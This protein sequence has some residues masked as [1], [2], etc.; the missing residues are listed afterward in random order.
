MKLDDL[1]HIIDGVSANTSYPINSADKLIQALGGDN[2]TIHSHKASELR[3][4]PAS[5]FP[6]ES[7]EDF[8]T[9]LSSLL[10]ESGEKIEGV[11]WAKTGGKPPSSAGAPP[12]IDPAD[13]LQPRGVPGARQHKPRP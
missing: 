13:Q 9:K 7:E 3:K 4:M 10:Q 5:Y 1:A 6:I 8:A 12:S 2:A 11:S